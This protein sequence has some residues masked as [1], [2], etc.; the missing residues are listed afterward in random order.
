VK[1]HPDSPP[2]TPRAVRW[3]LAFYS[4]LALIGGGFWIAEQVAR[5]RSTVDV[6]LQPQ[7]LF[8]AALA[9]AS[10]LLWRVTTRP[11]DPEVERALRDMRKASTAHRRC[12]TCSAPVVANELLCPSCHGIQRRE[13]LSPMLFLI[14]VG[15]FIT[16][17]LWRQ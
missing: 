9:L 14:L 17:I 2:L 5:G 10:A 3:R 7:S 6:L 15:A 12:N 13:L 8:L 11:L 4:F 16:W 1:V